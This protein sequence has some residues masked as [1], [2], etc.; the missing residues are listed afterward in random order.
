MIND[1]DVIDGDN[2]DEIY[3]QGNTV[4][5]ES[6]F[7]QQRYSPLILLQDGLVLTKSL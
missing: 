1:R 4:T 6:R 5:E 7:I 3:C 2:G